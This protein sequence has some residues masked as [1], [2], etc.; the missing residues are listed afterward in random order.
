MSRDPRFDGPGPDAVF[1]AALAEGRFLLQHCRD[2]GATRHPPALVCAGCG[3]AALDWR[4]ASGQGSVYSTTTV[5]ERDGAYNVSIIELAEGARLMS[6]VVGIAPE[7]VRIGLKVVARIAGGA[8][9]HLVF[10]PAGAE[11]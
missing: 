2:C 11:S 3:S 9:P 7:E 1:T 8:E 10:E 4:E 6:R 5:R